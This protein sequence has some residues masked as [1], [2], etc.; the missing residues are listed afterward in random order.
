MKI[1]ITESV[2]MRYPERVRQLIGKLKASGVSVSCDDFGTG[3]SNLASL[4][5]LQFDTLK[6]DR[7]FIANGGIEG[8]GGIILG[9]VI[10]L[11]HQLGMQVVA[12]G[13]EDEQQALLLE[14]IG[15]DMG[16]GY[17]LGEPKQA[18]D[19]PG[20][21]AVFPVV[22]ALPPLPSDKTALAPAPGRAPMAPR[23]LIPHEGEDA[24]ISLLEALADT[25]DDPGTAAEPRLPAAEAAEKPTAKPQRRKRG[26]KPR[27]RSAK[28]RK[29]RTLVDSTGSDQA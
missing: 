21:L 5:D 19:V 17:W 18:R 8:R 13:V 10:S 9:S 14:A 1:E 4:R 12:E 26:A 11:A 29:Q 24:E 15:A 7:S 23:R 3:F 6:M 27:K 20:L 25:G 28:P 22:D 2:A 16:Q